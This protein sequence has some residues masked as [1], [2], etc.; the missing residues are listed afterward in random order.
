MTL[1]EILGVAETASSEEIKK[2][3]RRLALDT[4]PDRHPGNAAKEEQFKQLTEAYEVLSVQDKR[5]RYDAELRHKRWEEQFR[6]VAAP[7]RHAQA[8]SQQEPS[9]QRA[10]SV[11]AAFVPRKHAQDEAEEGSFVGAFLAGLGLFGLAAVAIHQ[12]TKGDTSW[13]ESVGRNRGPD[14][15]FRSS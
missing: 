6:A 15:R 8:P 1:Y 13:D 11:S 9:S 12:A 5:S 3:F 14:G 4:H 2:A 10:P 7:T